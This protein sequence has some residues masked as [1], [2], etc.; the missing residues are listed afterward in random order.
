MENTNELLARI[1]R[2]EYQI[3]VLCSAVEARLPLLA[4]QTD[5]APT[6]QPAPAPPPNHIIDVGSLVIDQHRHSAT[7]HNRKLNLSPGEF[8]MLSYM[9]QR[10]QQVISPQQVARDVMGYRCEPWEARDLTKARV[11]ALRRKLEHDPADPKMLVS[12]RGVGYML[13]VA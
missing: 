3:G 7:L 13:T 8:A 2:L 5:P 6:P 11:W 12:V 10:H 1:E 4:R 9:A